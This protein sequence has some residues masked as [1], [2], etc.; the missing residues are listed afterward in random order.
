[1][2]RRRLSLNRP[3]QNI[4]PEQKKGQ[5]QELSHRNAANQKTDLLVWFAEKLHAHARRGVCN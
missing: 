2:L 5:R 1:M 3:V 4:K